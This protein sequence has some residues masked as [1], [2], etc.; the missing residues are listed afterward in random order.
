MPSIFD[1]IQKTLAG[2]TMS[3]IG[4]EL[5]TDER[6]TG[7]AAGAAVTAILGGLARNSARP[8]GA[9]ALAGALEKDH[10]GSIMDNLSGFLGNASAGPGDGI[11]RHVLG[12]RRAAVESG[13]GQ[14]SGLNRDQMGKLMTMLAPVV[15]GALGRAQ[16]ER[17][18][19]AT[20]LTGFLSQE[21]RTLG[22]R[23]TVS[24]G[25]LGRVMDA[26]GDGDVD[27]SDLIKK[28]GGLLGKFLGR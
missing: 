20:A 14:A 7:T 17:R 1:T 9:Q 11:L 26:D 24:L 6:T 15:M 13:L 10:D 23:E 3:R 2:D 28:G 21:S 5:G 12:N 22:G 25:I 8:G 16:R 27:V 19:D 18:M 4:R